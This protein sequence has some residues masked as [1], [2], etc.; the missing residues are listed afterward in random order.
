ML[1]RS[2]QCLLKDFTSQY[3][4]EIFRDKEY[5]TESQVIVNELDR[6]AHNKSC[7]TIAQLAKSVAALLQRHH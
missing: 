5:V 6:T 7:V 4:V 1:V 2:E 3:L